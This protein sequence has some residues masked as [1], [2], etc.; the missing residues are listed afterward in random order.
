MEVRA[1]ALAAATFAGLTIVAGSAQAVDVAVLPASV[2]G[3]DARLGARLGAVLERAFGA[4]GN[5]V[6]PPERAAYAVRP[7]ITKT[8]SRY[9]IHLIAVRPSD[10]DLLKEIARR[11]AP[12]TENEAAERLRLT[13]ET[14]ELQL[15]FLDHDAAAAKPPSAAAA[16]VANAPGPPPPVFPLSSAAA[17]PPPALTL[18]PPAPA[19]AAAVSAAPLLR[20]PVS[21]WRRVF[22]WVGMAAGGAAMAATVPLVMY[23]TDRTRCEQPDPLACENDVRAIGVGAAVVLA[24]ALAVGTS[25][26][27]LRNLSSGRPVERWRWR[28]QAVPSLLAAAGLGWSAAAMILDDGYTRGTHAA[29]WAG[30]GLATLAAT[31]AVAVMF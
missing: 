9:E 7:R 23:A 14:L 30:A 3:M 1:R 8:G 5:R 16:P 28:L 20:A 11:C 6:V 10:G 24:G 31:G 17:Q 2:S 4:I 18:A 19:A 15:R 22:P 13:A 21:R 29:A 25:A 12:C 27:Q 26:G